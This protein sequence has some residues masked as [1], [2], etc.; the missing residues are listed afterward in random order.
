MYAQLDHDLVVRV[1]FDGSGCTISQA[2]ADLTAEWP[3]ANHAVAIRGLGIDD[4]L[5]RLGRQ[6]VQTRLAALRS[7]CTACSARS[8]PIDR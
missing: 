2:A 6:V 1:S 3:K 4:V 8:P 7:A 5:D